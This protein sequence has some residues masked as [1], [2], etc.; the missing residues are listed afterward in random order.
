MAKIRFETC[1]GLGIAT[2]DNP[3]VNAV[4]LD[5]IPDFEQVLAQI[6]NSNIRGLLFRAA[7]DNFSAGADVNMFAGQSP[8][9][10]REMFGEFF[11]L[12]H[13]FEALPFPTMA[14]VQGLCLT[15]GLEAALAMDMIWASENAMFGQAEALIGAIPFG[16]GAQRLAARAGTARAKEIVFSARFYPAQRFLDYQVI[17]RVLPDQDLLPKALAYMQN[18]ADNGPTQAF[19]ATKKI[20]GCFQDKGLDAADQMTR[21][22]GADLFATKDFQHGVASFL[23]D[24]PGNITF[25]GK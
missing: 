4:G 25:K 5:M 17:N 9:Q 24:G 12:L 6:D 22:L 20:M 13:R 18:L 21:D 7:G 19:A 10:A 3:P 15:A 8:A 23:T 2:L 11:A 14:V 1:N 16:G